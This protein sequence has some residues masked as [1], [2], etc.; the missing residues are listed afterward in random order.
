MRTNS[1]ACEIQL[2]PARRRKARSAVIEGLAPA[3]SRPGSG[4]PWLQWLAL[5]C[6]M[7]ITR[8][9]DCLYSPALRA[10]QPYQSSSV[11]LLAQTAGATPVKLS[12]YQQRWRPP[13]PSY[14][15][16]PSSALRAGLLLVAG[17]SKSFKPASAAST[18]RTGPLA[19]RKTFCYY[20]KPDKLSAEAGYLGSN[21]RHTSCGT[22]EVKRSASAAS[23]RTPRLCI[24]QVHTHSKC[25]S[26]P[27]QCPMALPVDEQRKAASS[28]QRASQVHAQ[29]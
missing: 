22:Y 12:R 29:E 27:S 13:N 6:S 21:L 15:M 1:A 8:W 3:G 2:D 24:P 18:M 26:Q 9:P 23:A 19:C 7:L 5:H 20:T 17:D 10:V 14:S 16:M 4:S 25:L 28:R 11:R